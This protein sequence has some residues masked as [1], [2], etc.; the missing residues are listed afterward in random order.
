MALLLPNGICDRGP[1]PVSRGAKHRRTY[2]TCEQWTSGKVRGVAGTAV[3]CEQ[4][5]YIIF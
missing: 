2:F 4:I 3:K 1:K 5:I